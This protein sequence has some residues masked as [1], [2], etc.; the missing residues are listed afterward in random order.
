VNYQLIRSL[1][2]DVWSNGPFKNIFSLKLLSRENKNT[3]IN[4]T[5]SMWATAYIR[6]VA[7]AAMATICVAGAATGFSLF[8]VFPVATAIIAPILFIGVLPWPLIKISWILR[9]LRKVVAT[10]SVNSVDVVNQ[11]KKV[12]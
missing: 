3:N 11:N 1:H 12:R 7:N 9:G 5:R 2:Q 8:A 4:P 10:P 6:L